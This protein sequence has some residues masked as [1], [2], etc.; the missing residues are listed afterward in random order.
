VEDGSIFGLVGINGAGKTTLLR[1][2]AGVCQP[3]ERKIT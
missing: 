3:D 2:T 1:L